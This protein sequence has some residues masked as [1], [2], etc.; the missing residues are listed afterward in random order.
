MIN[1]DE[2]Y[3]DGTELDRRSVVIVSH[4]TWMEFVL[5]W[6]HTPM[7]WSDAIDPEIKSRGATPA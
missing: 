4:H 5:C 6:I 3:T 7:S 1:L 2:G